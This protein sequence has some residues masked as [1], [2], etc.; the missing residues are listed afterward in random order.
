MFEFPAGKLS[1]VH[2]HRF[3]KL[4]QLGFL[5]ACRMLEVLAFSP[6]EL[7][8]RRLLLKLVGHAFEMHMP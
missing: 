2:A 5:W 6:T 3:M 1:G 4:K 7:C 8:T